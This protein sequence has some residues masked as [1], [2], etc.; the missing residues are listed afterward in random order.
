MS[1]HSN[2]TMTKTLSTQMCGSLCLYL[3]PGSMLVSEVGFPSFLP[4]FLPSLLSS[5]LPFSFL[6]CL[7]SLRAEPRSP[8]AD[9]L[10]KL[11]RKVLN[12]LTSC[13]N[14]LSTSFYARTTRLGFVFSFCVYYWPWTW[15][16]ALREQPES[17]A[18][19]RQGTYCFIMQV[20][21]GGQGRLNSG[22]RISF[23][24]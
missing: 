10:T 13:L 16:P 22:F 24:L 18:W 7:S 8:S 9:Y 17:S 21:L 12:L 3:S 2:R 19:I 23:L 14:L 6:L 5:W 20:E 11:P 1:P 15:L 4:S